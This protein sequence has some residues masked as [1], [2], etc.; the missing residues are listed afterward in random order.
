MGNFED[1]KAI[2]MADPFAVLEHAGSYRNPESLFIAPK[3]VEVARAL[4]SQAEELP[5]K[6]AGVYPK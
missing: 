5:P 2:F 3:M 4:A 1:L 6:R